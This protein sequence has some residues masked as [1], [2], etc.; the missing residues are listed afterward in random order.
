[1]VNV[2]SIIYFEALCGDPS[3]ALNVQCTRLYNVHGFP[4][5]ELPDNT[6]SFQSTTL[7]KCILDCKCFISITKTGS[8]ISTRGRTIEGFISK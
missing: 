5:V 1:M 2:L 4:C 7:R 3:N 8:K 6:K